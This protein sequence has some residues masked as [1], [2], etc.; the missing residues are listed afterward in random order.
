MKANNP[1]KRKQTAY[2]PGSVLRLR[3]QPTIG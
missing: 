1:K 2:E 3:W